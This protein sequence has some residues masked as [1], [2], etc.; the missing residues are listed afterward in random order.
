VVVRKT[1]MLDATGVTDSATGAIG[2]AIEYK[3]FL[4]DIKTK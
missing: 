4:N 3:M 1:E 2:E